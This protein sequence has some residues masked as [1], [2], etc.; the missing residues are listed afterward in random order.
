MPDKVNLVTGGTGLLGSHIV[1]QL[2]AAG[3]RVRALV[4][5]GSDARFLEQ[6]GVEIVRGSL[7]DADSVRRAVEGAD[8]VYH[9]AAKVSD[10]GPWKEFEREAVTSTR[11][12]VEACKS[13]GVSRLLHVST[14]S[15]YG[16]INPPKGT[17]ITED[18]PLGTRFRW[19]DYYPQSKILAEKIAWELGEKVTVTRPSWMYG[20]RD[21]SA[22]P[23]LVKALQ[24]RRVP[25]I[26][27]GDNLLN[28]MYAGDV[29]AGC[30]LAANNP[31]AKGQAYHLCSEGEITQKQMLDTLTDALGLPRITQHRLF[32]VVMT[33]AFLKELFAKL[34]MRKTAPTPTRRA[35][36][37]IA[38]RSFFS[39]AKAQKELG[40]RPQ[41][42]PV[43][44]VRISLEWYFQSNGLP[45][46]E[47][48]KSTTATPAAVTSDK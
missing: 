47:S 23:R 26:G 9:S 10:W 42:N 20:A 41:M 31:I 30:I 43:E 18:Q 3:E 37:L 7:E 12:M 8:I 44:G 2:R 38:R 4:R 32:P 28:I 33:F 17:L 15:V 14:I 5:P 34:L 40:W 25:V 1:E 22:I 13:A 45:I 46:P 36:Y 16:T 11:N 21:R 39:T 6:L 29:A 48:L 24:A 27:K 19:W 35:V